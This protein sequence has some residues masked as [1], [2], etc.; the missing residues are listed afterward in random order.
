MLR[1]LPRSGGGGGETASQKQEGCQTASEG[2]R[3]RLPPYP[4]KSRGSSSCRSCKRE[5]P[6]SM[7]VGAGG[8]CCCCCCCCRRGCCLGWTLC[9]ATLQSRGQP[10]RRTCS[11]LGSG[12]PSRG[13]DSALLASRRPR[14]AVVWPRGT[15]AASQTSTRLTCGTYHAASRLGESGGGREGGTP[16]GGGDSAVGEALEQERQLRP[17]RRAVAPG[18]VA[19]RGAEKDAPPRIGGA[20]AVLGWGRGGGEQGM[21]SRAAGVSQRKLPERRK[22]HAEGTPKCKLACRASLHPTPWVSAAT[23]SQ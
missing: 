6:S 3:E 23:I 20:D 1:S 9:G 8:G 19:G 12:Q 5:I 11:L 4:R 16:G 22:A 13:K 15:R 17:S 2:A 7:V 10:R 14:R 18:A 21:R